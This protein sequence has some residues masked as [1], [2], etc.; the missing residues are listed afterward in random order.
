MRNT[1]DVGRV[2]VQE[3]MRTYQDYSGKLHI[4]IHFKV[5][6]LTKF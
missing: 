1:F 5:Y 6:M 2:T 4:L 3:Y